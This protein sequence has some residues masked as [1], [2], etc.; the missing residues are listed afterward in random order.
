MA[1]QQGASVLTFFGH[2]L[3][4]LFEHH[5]SLPMFLGAATALMFPLRHQRLLQLGI[6]RKYLTRQQ[7]VFFHLTHRYYLCKTFSRA[8]RVKAALTHYSFEEARYTPAYRELVYGGDGLLL[9]SRQIA[10]STYEVKLQASAEN[11]HEGGIGV[12]LLSNN[13]RLSE[14]SFAWVQGAVFGLKPG[15]LAFITRNQSINHGAHE[16]SEF[17]TAFPHNSPRYFCLAAVQGVAAAHGIEHV[18]AIRHDRQISYLKRQSS[19]F[20]NSYSKLWQDL[21]GVVVGRDAYLLPVP[22]PVPAIQEIEAK[23]RGRARRRRAVWNEILE[24]TVVSVTARRRP[25]WRG[26]T[27]A[28]TSSFPHSSAPRPSLGAS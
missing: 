9:W 14:I 4:A 5:R 2:F 20:E 28:P 13:I 17:R 3:K 22:F 16:L 26:S 1:A 27:D 25:N 15:V 12:V 18:A 11:R 19:T 24:E 21:G 8:Q 7:N 10:G 23:H 6:Y